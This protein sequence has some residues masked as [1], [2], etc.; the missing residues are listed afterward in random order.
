MKNQKIN[1]APN[2]SERYLRTSNFYAAAY[3]YTKACELIN[4]D[5][6]VDS[7]RAEFVFVSNPETALFFHIFNFAKDQ[8]PDLQINV[9][10][11]IT[12]IKNLKT[13]LYQQEE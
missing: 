11:F 5:K 2:D 4:V 9:R 13:L 6:S 8:E 7:K 12:A 3:L 10:T 1:R